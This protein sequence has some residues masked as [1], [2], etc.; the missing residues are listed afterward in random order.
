VQPDDVVT[1]AQG[2][3][4]GFFNIDNLLM[5]QNMVV[6]M[7][8]WSLTE[9]FSRVF[10]GAPFLDRVIIFL[11]LVF[12]LAIV[13]LTAERQPQATWGERVLLGT[14]LGTVT[15]WGHIA[16]KKTGLLSPTLPPVFGVVQPTA[17]VES[18]APAEG[19]RKEP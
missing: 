1:H 3:G 7:A 15:V 14:L 12:S 17:E 11:P 5:P 2:L 10:K 8:S 9:M 19:E 4:P 18:E 16:G 6:I 13:F